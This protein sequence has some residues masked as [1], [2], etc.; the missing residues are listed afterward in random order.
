MIE[1]KKTIGSRLHSHVESD[2]TR[3]PRFLECETWGT[4]RA[5]PARSNLGQNHGPRFL[6]RE[7][8]GTRRALP[9]RSN[10]GQEEKKGR[11]DL[12]RPCGIEWMELCYWTS[13]LTAVELSNSSGT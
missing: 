9:A 4:R 12:T 11:V 8:W 3:G 13:V 5:S 10:H 6:K 2:Q 7:T 1:S